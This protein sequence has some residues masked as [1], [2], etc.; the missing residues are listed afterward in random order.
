MENNVNG[1]ASA[2]GSST[3]STMDFGMVGL[4]VMGINF[5]LNL[6]DH[7]YAVAGLDL[8]ASKVKTLQDEG[9]EGKHVF[10]TGYYAD[11]VLSLKKPRVIMMLVPAGKPVDA[12][13]ESVLP[14]LEPGDLVID[15][16]N[17]YFT[18]TDRRVSYLATKQIH[19]LGVGVS[20][21]EKGARYGPSIMPGGD[22]EAYERVRPMFEAVAAKVNGE[23]CVA[24]LGE[25]SA[26]N[27]VK[28]V[29]NGIEYGLMELIGE[30]YDLLKKGLGKNDAEI[31]NIYTSWNSGQLKS[32]LL[33]ITSEIFGYKD[34]HSED[35]LLNKISDQARQKGTGKWTSQNAMDLQVPLP[36]VDMAVTVRDTS[37]Y[38][39]LREMIAGVYPTGELT[40]ASQ[41]GASITD[42]SPQRIANAFY[43]AMLITYAQGMAML[44]EAAKE[45]QYSYRPEEIARIWR[46]G[47]IIRAACLEDI[48]AAFSKTPDLQNILLDKGIAEKVIANQE[49]LRATVVFAA[50]KGIPAG[51]LMA[52]LSYLDTFR[53]ANLPTNLTQAQRDYFGSHTYQR[54]DREGIFH[55]QWSDPAESISPKSKV[56]SS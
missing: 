2:G 12:V 29:H 35:L 25:R 11:F 10:G 6:A 54:I 32:F 27:Y 5:L 31:K 14:N 20:G 41:N 47:C 19:F 9:K 38:K 13:I 55:T 30:T 8:D 42:L 17:S 51:A 48:R 45:Y 43:A 16:G 49:D 22:K 34:D 37:A 26:G 39:E 15:G 33:E 24:Y 4:G 44:T 52:S 50:L 36:T 1:S 23:P 3:K 21:G 18:D 40:Q 7:G 28:T 53:A 46:G 56:T